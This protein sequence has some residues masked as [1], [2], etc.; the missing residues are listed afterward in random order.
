[1]TAWLRHHLLSLRQTV[2][3]MAAAPLAMLANVVVLGVV[4]ALPL[5]A[6]GLLINL[7]AFSASIPTEP[8]ISLFMAAGRHRQ[9]IAVLEGQIRKMAGVRAVQ[10][11]PRETALASLK[12]SPGISEVIASLQENPLPDAFVVT[13]SS[14]DVQLVQQLEQS[15]RALPGVAQIQVDSAWVRRLDALLSLGRTAVIVL[16]TLLG[17]ALVA[18]TF[19]T[20]RLQVLTQREEIEVSR[21]V[22]ATDSFIRRP[23]FYLGTLLGSLGALV[24]LGIVALVFAIM[25]RHLS[26]LGRFYGVEPHLAYFGGADAFTVIAFAALLGWLGTHLSVSRH[27]RV[28][29]DQ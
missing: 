22:G 5:G 9:D 11:I 12:R 19:N 21:L 3:R 25:N 2:L 15:M 1:V 20:V 4:L 7:Q 10:F 29:Q 17:F 26:Q 13:L 27:L 16:A 14:G 23:F 28:L 24:G 18:V 8:Q 6:Y